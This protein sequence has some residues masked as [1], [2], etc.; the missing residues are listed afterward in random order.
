[1]ADDRELA[2]ITKDPE[3]Y[4]PVEILFFNLCANFWRPNEPYT[5]AEY[6]RPNKGSGYAY[7]ANADGLSGQI[8]PTWN[9][10]L[11]G[12]T[13]DGSITWTTSPAATNGLS[14]I[15]NPTAT[16]EPAGLTINNLTVSE[17]TKLLATYS[18][19]V[20][21]QDYDVKFAVTLQAVPRVRRQKVK[22]RLR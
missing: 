1:M 21:G 17:T 5:A 6:V 11:G 20:A 2:D 14:A 13:T 12:L 7:Q 4:R 22:V 3:E 18:G 8:E 19:G 10:T 9:R 16:S 15:S